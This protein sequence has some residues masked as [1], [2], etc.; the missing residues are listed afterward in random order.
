MNDR[1]P[2]RAKKVIAVLQRAV[3]NHEA[4]N[5]SLFTD[6]DC[7]TLKEYTMRRIQTGLRP[8]AVGVKT[9]AAILPPQPTELESRTALSCPST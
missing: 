1:D 2:G 5:Y 3:V 6:P 4:E 7:H 8:S 9:E